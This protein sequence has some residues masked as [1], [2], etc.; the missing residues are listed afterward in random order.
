MF[1]WNL[2]VFAFSM[3]EPPRGIILPQAPLAVT[4]SNSAAGG[5]F[6]CINYHVVGAGSGQ[7][8]INETAFREQM[9]LLSSEGYAVESFE[10][11]EERLQRS[12]PIPLRYVT[13]TVD[14]GH[15]SSL[16][17]AEILARYSFNA[18]FFVTRDRCRHK[19]GYI[20]EQQIR[21]LRG[22]GF[23]VGAHGTSH[24]KL[25]FLP[26]QQAAAELS[27]SKSWLESVVGEPVRYMAAPGGYINRKLLLMAYAY[28]Y[29][30][31]G[32]CSEWMNP[33]VL[34]VP[35]TV[36]R[37][38]IRRHFSLGDFRRIIVGNTGFYCWRQLRAAALA[39]PKQFI[40]N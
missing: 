10:Q 1:C 4:A 36:N 7:Y 21:Q 2:L 16:W 32:T 19:S 22:D 29:S 23:S 6:A 31:V 17:V 28:G 30:L 20:R 14:D 37:V 33:G 11:L 34:S 8:A 15:E 24:R 39:I 13:L 18:T 38:N 26:L 3:P 40:G 12:V 27:E 25:T 9:T 5:R 35:C